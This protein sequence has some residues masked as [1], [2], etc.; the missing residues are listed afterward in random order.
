[1]ANFSADSSVQ[2]AAKPVFAKRANAVAV[3]QIRDGYIFRGVDHSSGI[4]TNSRAGRQIRLGYFFGEF[5]HS[6]GAKIEV[7][8]KMDAAAVLQIRSGYFS[9]GFELAD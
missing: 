4:K 2:A 5:E 8:E 3:R 6:G 9:G 7:C 1:M